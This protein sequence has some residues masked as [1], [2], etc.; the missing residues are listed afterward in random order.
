M[1]GH[2]WQ[3]LVMAYSPGGDAGITTGS[4]LGLNN[5]MDVLC[6]RTM[7]WTNVGSLC[8]VVLTFV[9]AHLG[10]CSPRFVLYD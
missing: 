2:K 9:C 10:L 7:L 8:A 4:E 6:C 3:E 5:W 1:G